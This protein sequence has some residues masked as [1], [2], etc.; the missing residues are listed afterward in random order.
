MSD[1]DLESSDGR[2]S[3]LLTRVRRSEVTQGIVRGLAL[4]ILILAAFH[5]MQARSA[6]PI[7]PQ[8]PQAQQV[9]RPTGVSVAGPQVERPLLVSAAVPQVDFGAVS[10]STQVRVFARWLDA[11]GD[12]G[13][14]PFFIIDKNEARLYVFGQDAQLRAATPVLLGG[15]PGDHTVAGIGER[16][17]ADIRPHERTTP[18][19][20]FV[21][22]RGRNA[23][24]EE[25]VWVDYDAAVSMHRVL[26]TNR[27][28]RRLERLNTE[29]PEDNRISYGC[30]NV[31]AKFF[32]DHVLPVVVRAHAIVYILP[33]TRSLAEVFGIGEDR[34]QAPSP[35][36][37]APAKLP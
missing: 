35:H 15:A 36:P 34:V 21:G 8:L 20:R 19:G 1:A 32:D 5:L 31:P 16:A 29:T 30:I 26:T 10:P 25:V 4:G 2:R 6:L 12:A 11:S 13:G 24:G 22:E 33:E 28:E 37:S 9:D 17:I 14:L 27:A 23:R 3:S 18:A 7:P